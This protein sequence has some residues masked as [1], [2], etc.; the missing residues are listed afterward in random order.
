MTSSS[1]PTTFP[2]TKLMFRKYSDDSM[3]TDFLSVQTNA[4]STSLPA[5]TSDTCCL[6]KASPWPHT[7]SRLSKIGLNLGKS[8]MFNPSSVSPTS[9]VVS[10]TDIPKSQFCLCILPARV[11]PGTFPMSA[12]QPLKHLKRL[13]LQLRSL[14]IGSR[15]PKLQLKL[16]IP[17][18]L[19][20]LSF[21]LP[22][23]MASFTRL[24]STPG[25]FPLRNSITTSMTKSYLR[26]L[27]LSNDGDITSKA[28]DF[29]STWSPITRICNTF[30]RP[31]SSRVDKHDGP[32]IFL[33]STSSSAS[34]LENSE[35][36]PMHLLDDGTSILK[37]GIATM[38]VSIHRT[39]AR[40]SLP[41]NWH[42]PSELLPYPSQPF[43]DLSP[44]ILKGSIP[45]FGL[46]SEMI[47]F[48][49]NTSTI[50]QTPRGPLVLMVY[51]ATLDTF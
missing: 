18:M 23:R 22:H 9:T 34:I 10:F 13:S 31:K 6:P 42:H 48:P 2:S 3:L 16:T 26:Y 47:P 1:I 37:R 17:T 33:A 49:Q 43:V 11:P 36:N 20:P 27:K 32:N 7:R 4:S 12:V 40:Y 41:S 35:P 19:S 39:S 8:R 28:L 14:P 50:S 15:T 5:N 21:R 44:W 38:P 30:Q 51:Y 24:H 25:L 45:T 46:N 29:Q